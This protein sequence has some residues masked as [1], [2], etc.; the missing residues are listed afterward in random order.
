[1]QDER[2]NLITGSLQTLQFSTPEQVRR[3]SSLGA[4][5]S[6]NVYY[7]HELSDS[8]SQTGIGFD[9]LRKWRV[10]AAILEQES[11]LQ[12]TPISPWHLRAAQ[13]M[14]VA[15]SRRNH[16]GNIMGEPESLSRKGPAVRSDQRGSCLRYARDHGKYTGG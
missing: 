4:Q 14:W 6:A 7:L 10:W 16:V 1:M 8:Y 5:V 2:P 13:R 12:S 15:V 3:I 9:A 11:I